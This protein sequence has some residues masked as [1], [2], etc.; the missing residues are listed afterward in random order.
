MNV[1]QGYGKSKKSQRKTEG[2]DPRN[3]IYLSGTKKETRA[4][5]VRMVFSADTG[6]LKGQAKPR[7]SI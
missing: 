2:E 1:R 7:T 6:H 3:E 4:D 5:I